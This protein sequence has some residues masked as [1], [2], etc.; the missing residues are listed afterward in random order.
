M[1]CP[2]SGVL[3]VYSVEFVSTFLFVT[4]CERGGQCEQACS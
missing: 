4:E 3:G 1:S 2:S